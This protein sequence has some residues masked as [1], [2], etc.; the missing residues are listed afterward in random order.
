MSLLGEFRSSSGVADDGGTDVHRFTTEKSVEY[1]DDLVAEGLFA[2]E[3]KV[4]ERY[5]E[6]DDTVLDVGCG[7]GRTTSALHDR[8]F[9]VVGLD[10]SAPLV[11]R[12]GERFPD[13]DFRVGDAVDLDVPGAS[14]DQVLFSYNGICCIRPESRRLEALREF[15]RVLK[16]GGLLAFSSR[17]TWYRYPAV[18][19]DHDFLSRFYL[20]A[21]NARRFF[22]PYKIDRDDV[23][24]P[25][26]IYFATPWRQRRQL[27][28]CGFEPVD[29]VGERNGLG[30]LFETMPYYVARKA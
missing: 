6:P 9:D 4:V 18:L 13:I 25:F 5:Y 14:Y 21:E 3:R 19:V 2:P 8:G 1:Y 10:A 15:H 23:G 30:R 22:H 26:E 27:R 12:A 28:D 7:A 29:I 16:P 17:N 20:N 11:A 24:E